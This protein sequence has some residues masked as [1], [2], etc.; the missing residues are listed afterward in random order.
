MKFIG[1]PQV[2]HYSEAT[3]DIRL[4]HEFK[5]AVLG[6]TFPS[7]LKEDCDKYMNWYS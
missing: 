5:E 6:T 4:L 3:H 2:S 1:C 7:S